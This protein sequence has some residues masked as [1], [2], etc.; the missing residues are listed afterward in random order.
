MAEVSDEKVQDILKTMVSFDV[1]TDLED[2]EQK[3]NLINMF[4][5]LVD[6]EDDVTKTFLVKMFSSMSDILVDMGIIDAE[7]TDTEEADETPTEEPK[8]NIVDVED[9]EESKKVSYSELLADRAND[10]LMM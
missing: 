10:F 4:T 6:S 5:E 7:E 3:Q 9:L 1:E 8:E 2:D